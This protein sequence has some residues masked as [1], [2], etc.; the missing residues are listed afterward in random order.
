MCVFAWEDVCDVKH[1]NTKTSEMEETRAAHTR[2]WKKH[3]LV[4][5]MYF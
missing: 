2:P 1:G 3:L 4:K 5:Q